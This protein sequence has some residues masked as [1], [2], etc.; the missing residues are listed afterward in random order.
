ML[1]ISILIC[2]YNSSESLKIL[3]E[4]IKKVLSPTEYSFEIVFIDDGSH[5][6]ETWKTIENLYESNKEVV[7]AH[8]LMRNFGRPSA[9]MCGF[10]KCSGDYI[11]MMDDDLQHDPQYILNFLNSKEH[12]V[13]IAHFEDKKHNLFKRVVSD[14]K[15]Y[16]DYKLIGKPRHIK[17]SSFK[18]IKKPIIDCINNLSVTNPFI[19]G[20]IFYATRDIVNIKI[21][22]NSREYGDSGFTLRKMIRQFMNLLFN[23]SSFLLRMV[24]YL[25]IIFSF[26]GFILAIVYLGRYFIYGSNFPGWTSIFVL[27][28]ITSGLILFSLGI[29]GEYFIRIIQLSEKRPSYVIRQSKE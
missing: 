23:N 6:V 2:V 15:G 8:Q 1:K 20:L 11:I 22:H 28:I 5:N 16:F 19:S 29:F 27:N 13:V 21:K 26:F 7:K 10:S 4:K 25:G 24:S 3:V 12:D 9:L 14:I 17:N 18:M